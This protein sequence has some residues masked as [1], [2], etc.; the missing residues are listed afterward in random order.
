MLMLTVILSEIV[1][2]RIDAACSMPARKLAGA[3]MAAVSNNRLMVMP[4]DVMATT[5]DGLLW[6]VES[7]E[8]A[9]EEVARNSTSPPIRAGS[10]PA[11][12]EMPGKSS[13]PRVLKKPSKVSIGSVK[14]FDLIT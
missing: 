2:D 6:A 3:F 10:L 8:L 7:V 1:A 11:G 14:N 12:G 13:D 9:E 5:E 4:P